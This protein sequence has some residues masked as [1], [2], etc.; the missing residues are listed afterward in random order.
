[1]N[2]LKNIFNRLSKELTDACNDKSINKF[3][4]NDKSINKVIKECSDEVHLIMRDYCKHSDILL[5]SLKNLL[6]NY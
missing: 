4:N 2:T 6:M 1:M 5:R 3:E